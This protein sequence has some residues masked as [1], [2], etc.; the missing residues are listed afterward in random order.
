MQVFDKN[1]KEITLGTIIKW[2]SSYWHNEKQEDGTYTHTKMSQEKEGP[3]QKI[4]YKQTKNGGLY[5]L[6]VSWTEKHWVEPWSYK[7]RDF[8][9]YWHTSGSYPSFP[10]KSNHFKTVEVVREGVIPD[11]AILTES[12]K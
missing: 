5:R 6:I 2:N 10:S 11:S 4:T 7:G 8:P 3:V 12:Y 1:G 9:G